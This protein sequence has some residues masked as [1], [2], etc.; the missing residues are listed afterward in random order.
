M[1]NSDYHRIKKKF[2]LL[3]G[4]GFILAVIFFAHGAFFKVWGKEYS[5]L[6]KHILYFDYVF[7]VTCFIYIYILIKFCIKY[8]DILSKN[9]KIFDSLNSCK[10]Q[11][12]T[13]K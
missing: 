1:A 12:K 7:L 6:P 3:I 10:K 9:H 8:D 13:R 4:L 11:P 2:W 5:I